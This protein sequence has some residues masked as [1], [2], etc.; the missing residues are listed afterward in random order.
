MDALLKAWCM[1]SEQAGLCAY[2]GRAVGHAGARADNSYCHTHTHSRTHT[3][4]CTR[5]STATM[6]PFSHSSP[7]R[8]EGR[9]HN[10]RS[11]CRDMGRGGRK[12][13][14]GGSEGR[15]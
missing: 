1:C 14:D 2:G 9:A 11:H 4:S 13:G 12:M 7:R 3:Q 15:L 5:R 10:G 6:T 8:S